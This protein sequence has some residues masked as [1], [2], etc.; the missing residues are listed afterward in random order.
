MTV[1][2][3]IIT[4]TLQRVFVYTRTIAVYNNCPIRTCLCF[5]GGLSKTINQKEKKKMNTSEYL[6]FIEVHA[7]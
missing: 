1:A 2:I 6:N 7:G 3:A 5:A 4:L